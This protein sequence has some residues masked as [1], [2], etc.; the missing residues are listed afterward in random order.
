MS[1]PKSIDDKLD[2]LLAAIAALTAFVSEIPDA[3]HVEMPKI[4][5]ALQANKALTD[6]QI[7]LAI[8]AAREIKHAV[9]AKHGDDH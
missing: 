3:K 9:Q 5:A 2:E 4:K 1:E 6:T 8:D 7:K